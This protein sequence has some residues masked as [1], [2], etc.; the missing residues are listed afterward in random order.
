MKKIFLFLSAALVSLAMQAEV[1]FNEE[2]AVGSWNA[3]QL[4]IAS[5][6]ILATASEGDVIAITVTASTDGRVVL[7][8]TAWEALGNY[9]AYHVSTGVCAFVLTSAAATEVKTNGLIVTGQNYTFDKVELL[10][11]KTLWEGSVY[12]S[13][14]PGWGQSDAL[15]NT[16]FADL[17]EGDLLGVTVSELHG[18]GGWYQ[19][20]FRANWATNILEHQIYAAGTYA[21]ALTAAQVTS[22]QNDVIA[23]VTNYATAT[24]IHTYVETKDVTLWSGTQEVADW[25]GS[26][27]IDASK[28]T[29]LKVGNIL[30]VN[31]SELTEGGQVYLQYDDGAWKSYSAGTTC[32]YVFTGS[33][34]APMTVEIPV[35]YKLEKQL[36]GNALIV[37][38]QYY[39]MTKVY[40]KEGTPVNTVAAYLNVSDAGMATYILPFDVPALPDGVQAYDLT[41]DGSNV[42]MATEVSALEADKP[43]LIVAAEGEYEFVSEEG[44]S[45]DIS[46]KTGTY[47]NGALIGT[48]T[49]IAE[50]EQTTAGNYNYILSKDGEG[51]VAFYQ[52]QDN[53]CSVAPYRAYLSCG[54]NASSAPA[55]APKM[56][57]VF[58]KGG[59]TGVESVQQSAISN[60]KIIRNG[61][62]FILRNGV[63]YNV[64]GQ[65]TK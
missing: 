43:V 64:N 12:D 51:K 4:P 29:D 62:L 16:L 14:N 56:R 39:T 7:Q 17:Q 5:Y 13:E 48:Y 52:V 63:E 47:A 18:D 35:T 61:Q 22:L 24:A 8:N 1:V 36:R 59:T 37:Q 2:H 55:G 57:I 42:I 25:S 54:Y 65:M 34:A 60:Q 46:G 10:Y 50:L 44:A 26:V 38:G 30:C 9:D 15:A 33:D 40:V 32:N 45:D 21:E 6:P 28:L 23:L 41:N 58:H 11:Q 19:Y 27:R 31:V 49:A 53:S 20:N 3:Q